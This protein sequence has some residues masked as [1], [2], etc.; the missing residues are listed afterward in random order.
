VTL[1]DVLALATTVERSETG[2]NAPTA[3]RI[4]ATGN[5]DYSLRAKG[6]YRQCIEPQPTKGTF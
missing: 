2:T 1:L 5:F 4:L 3:G 6:D